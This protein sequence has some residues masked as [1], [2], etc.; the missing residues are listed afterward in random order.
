M[1]S[2]PDI[3]SKILLKYVVHIPVLVPMY[4]LLYVVQ[5]SEK[6]Y[7]LEKSRDPVFDSGSLSYIIMQLHFTFSQ[8]ITQLSQYYS[9]KCGWKFISNLVSYFITYQVNFLTNPVDITNLVVYFKSGWFLLQIQWILQ[10]LCCL[11]QIRV[12]QKTKN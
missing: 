4:Q 2:W 10:I 8:C 1:R 6:K 7:E 3:W 12:V 9:L 5:Q 11:F